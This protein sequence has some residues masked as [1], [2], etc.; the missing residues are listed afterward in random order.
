MREY[1]SDPSKATNPHAQRAI[2]KEASVN[3]MRLPRP[4]AFRTTARNR[5]RSRLRGSGACKPTDCVR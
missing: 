1:P 4:C 5:S 2:V 3:P